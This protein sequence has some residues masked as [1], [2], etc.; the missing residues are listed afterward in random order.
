MNHTLMET[1]RKSTIPSAQRSH[2][3]K[4]ALLA[5]GMISALPTSQ[6]ALWESPAWALTADASAGGGYDTN[7]Y[8]R[9]DGDGD[10]FVSFLPSLRL[11]RRSSLTKFEVVADVNAVKFFK[12]D[13]EDSVDPSI[14]LIC[15]Y[16]DSEETLSSQELR[17]G[18]VQTSYANS[19]VGRRVRQSDA[20]LFWEGNVAATGKSS[21][22]GRARLKHTDYH[23]IDYNTN[24]SFD[25]GA[26]YNFVSNERLNLGL[27]YELGL[28]RSVPD[29]ANSEKTNSVANEVTV[30]GRGEFLPKVSGRFHIGF[31]SISYTGA[32][33]SSDQDIVAGAVLDWKARERLEISSKLD[34]DTYFSPDGIVITRTSVALL[35]AQELVGGFTVL[36]EVEGSQSDHERENL[37]R[38]D[39]QIHLK[40]GLKYAFNDRFSAMANC[41]WTTQESDLSLYNYD[42]ALFSGLVS[43]R[44]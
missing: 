3:L 34:R 16:P 21:I 23:E 26:T 42:R 25:V 29:T 2:W 8:A 10:S 24:E 43:C 31:A 22:Q 44:F 36:G 5:F 28:S 14:K 33:E 37:Q 32:R 35:A 1:R 30:R 4:K 12:Y 13:D 9:Q 20:E 38:R 40:A 11:F 39:D 7:L 17:A 19:D 27:G 41:T 18:F 15:I 6:A